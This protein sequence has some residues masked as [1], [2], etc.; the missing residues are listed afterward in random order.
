MP[1]F[2]LKATLL[3]LESVTAGKTVRVFSHRLP[4]GSRTKAAHECWML[5]KK[6]QGFWCEVEQER[7]IL[8]TDTV[9][10]LYV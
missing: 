4:F 9:F 1:D 5:K 6:N 7:K 2:S 10:V 3:T 8:R